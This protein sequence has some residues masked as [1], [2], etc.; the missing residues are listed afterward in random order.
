MGLAKWRH[1]VLEGDMSKCP[2]SSRVAD[3]TFFSPI[4]V[5]ATEHFD[6]SAVL[7]EAHHVHCATQPKSRR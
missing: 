2:G 7:A 3:I 6:M 5:L 1:R 4:S